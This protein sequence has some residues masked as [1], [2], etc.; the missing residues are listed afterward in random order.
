MEESGL[1]MDGGVWKWTSVGWWVEI[2]RELRLWV[3][4]LSLHCYYGIK[5]PVVL[6]YA[7]VL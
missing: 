2:R 3:E 7:Q 4:E 5:A 1:S 6:R